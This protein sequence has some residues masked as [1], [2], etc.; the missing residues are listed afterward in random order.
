MTNVAVTEDIIV[1]LEKASA[2]AENLGVET[3]KIQASGDDVAGDGESEE[4]PRLLVAANPIPGVVYVATYTQATA[5]GWKTMGIRPMGRQRAFVEAEPSWRGCHKFQTVPTLGAEFRQKSLT[6]PNKFCRLD[7]TSCG[8]GDDRADLEEVTTR[9]RSEGGG[10]EYIFP[11]MD[12]ILSRAIPSP[13]GFVKE[14]VE[15]GWLVNREA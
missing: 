12:R 15:S 10:M 13:E 14:M 6:P 7:R 8:D 4:D 1:D 5:G 11:N 3:D 2:T 9:E